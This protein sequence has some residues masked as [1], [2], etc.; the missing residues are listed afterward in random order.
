MNGLYHEFR[1]YSPVHD[2]EMIR[3][4]VFDARGAEYFILIPAADGR[5]YRE[6]R[7]EALEDIDTAIAQKC[8]PGQ[9]VVSAP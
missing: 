3:I 7:D 5:R 6:R 9:V 8:E 4:S 1:S 2:A